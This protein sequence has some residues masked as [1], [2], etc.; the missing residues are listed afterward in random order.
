[1]KKLI[2]RGSAR[3]NNLQAQHAAVLNEIQYLRTLDVVEPLREA[4]DAS[5]S[6]E[7]LD[8]LQ[9]KRPEEI[10]QGKVEQRGH[11]RLANSYSSF[12]SLIINRLCLTISNAIYHA[13]SH[14][15]FTLPTPRSLK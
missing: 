8:V 2:L 6:F 11:G 13:V 4:L 15:K 7:N 5:I 1:M 9:A 10:F 12:L 3:T 14:S